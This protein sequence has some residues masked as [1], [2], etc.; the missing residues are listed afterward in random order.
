MLTV[1]SLLGGDPGAVCMLLA[2][3]EL[4]ARGVL[5]EAC[6]SFE[7]SE[8]S[9]PVGE[10]AFH[11]ISSSLGVSGELE[12]VAREKER[13]P[14]DM[15][16]SRGQVVKRYA[17]WSCWMPDFERTC[18]GSISRLLGILRWRGPSRRALRCVYGNAG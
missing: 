4:T 15:M 7:C 1:A 14:M 10:E 5:D 12:G 9:E 13:E 11:M 17:V 6:E 16:G 8:S 3:P 18:P 2:E